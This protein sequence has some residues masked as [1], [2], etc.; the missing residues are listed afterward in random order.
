ME[1]R[2]AQVDGG[3]AAGDEP[4][5]LGEFGVGGGE[6]DFESFGFAGPAFPLGLFDAGGQVAADFFQ[7]WPLGWVNPKEGTSDAPLTELTLMFRQVTACFR[8]RVASLAA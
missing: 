7:S 2:D 6:A 4:V 3:V 8:C 5:G 1:G